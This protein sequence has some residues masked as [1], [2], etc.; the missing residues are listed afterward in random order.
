MS[1]SSNE[2][3][4]FLAGIRVVELAD[5]LGEYCG[6][7]LAGLGADVVKVEPV[8]GETTRSIGPFYQDVEGPDRSL[9]FWHYN[10]GKRSVVLDLDTDAGQAALAGLLAS[11]DVLL[12]TRPRG[13]LAGIGFD[14]RRLAELNPGLVHARITAFGDDGPWA[15]FSGSD[16]IHLALGGVM[17]NCGYDPEPDG[18]YDLPPVAPQMWQ[19]YHITGEMMA[20]S[21]MAALWHRDRTGEGQRVETSVHESVSK[22]TET[23][24]PNWIFQRQTHR[25]QTCR[26]SLPTPG[27]PVLAAT[28]DGRWTLPYN[29]YLPGRSTT[30]RETVA[31]L[32]RHGMAD[33][34]AEEKYEDGAYRNS[35]PVRKHLAAV[36]AA[37]VGR[38]LNDREIWR[39][40]QRAGL[41]WAPIR[42]P[43]ENLADDHWA[44]R[45]TFV[46]VDHPE[47]GR[48]FT[49]VG[50]KWVCDEVPWSTGTR[51]PLLG[52]H[53]Q[54]VLG[55]ELQPRSWPENRTETG[56]RPFALRGVRVL[57]LA[58]LLASAGA[59]RFFT[60]L[61][62]E[63]IKVEHSSRYDG[64]RFGT[65]FPP[66]GGRA[67]RDAA[68]GPI[69]NPQ[70][71]GPNRS[72]SFMEINSGK[73][74]LSL[75]LKTPRGMEILKQLIARADVVIEGF[76]PGTMERMG[77]GYA[78]LRKI[79]PSIVY[80][81]QSGMG[82]RGSYSTMR[83]YGPTAQAFSGLSD[84][85]G[86]P[87]PFA[88][89][90]IGY[91]YLDW[92]GAYNMSTAMMA[93][94]YRRQRT[95][96][97]CYIDASQVE[98]GLYLTGTAILDHSANGRRWSRYGN[99]SPYKP[100][101]PHGA[102]RA[103][104]DDRWIAIG[105]FTQTQ[106]E[107]LAKVISVQA[108]LEDA[109]F[110]DL[111]A[112]LK[113]QDL[114]DRLVGEAT[115]GWDAYELMATLQQN[116][117]PAGVCQTAQDRYETDP[118]LRHLNWL[119]ELDQTE[120]GRWPVKELPVHFEKTPAHIGG[121]INRSGPNY[122]EDTDH[123]LGTLLGLDTAEIA[124]LRADGVT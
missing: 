43:E 107:S 2:K 69:P 63:V 66:L 32:E 113:H 89:A 119:V 91:S 85:S 123:V 61:G 124:A 70:I 121:L 40:G 105:C 109:R 21:V 36:F 35:P 51:P 57:D 111:P 56:D 110:A 37:F 116:G 79:N 122:G 53:T 68:T 108:L 9:H 59:G 48:S 99:R 103:A 50:A 84:M 88:P 96:E 22:N 106:W 27:A 34:L 5:E 77:L 6:R 7:V 92:F 13:Y 100:A 19:A 30:W 16:L 28:K 114:L 14:A 73:L 93:A 45:G 39:E 90:G 95:G 86:L 74:G 20:T 31:M 72:G 23:D 80:V 11:S 29:T 3:A 67:E 83:S 12:E 10:L 81:Q 120:L 117:V 54:E 26:H 115:A 25:R 87:E 17:M 76:S 49:Y 94:L 104:G 47:H 65:A 71:P 62:A 42:R 98:T 38:F 97:G 15:H 52:E 64:M 8:G 58:W 78:E 101:A 4:G 24:L 75:N 33:D 46:E 112:R 60:A 102:Y 1:K 18:H 44:Q 41:P 55:S 82:Q 118:Q